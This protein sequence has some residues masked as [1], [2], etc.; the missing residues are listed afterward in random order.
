MRGHR[1]YPPA[2]TGQTAGGRST[3][4]RST[5]RRTRSAVSLRPG[6]AAGPAAPAAPAATPLL[7][8]AVVAVER[9]GVVDDLGFGGEWLVRLGGH[10]VV[11]VVVEVGHV[12]VRRRGDLLDPVGG[13]LLGPAPATA[14][15]PLGHRLGV[16]HHATALAV[17]TGLAERL[18]EAGAD[19]LA[20]P[21]HKPQRGP[22][23]DLV[24]GPVPAEALGQPAQHQVTVA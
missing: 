16:D 18:Q 13:A 22:L 4:I 17:L 6:P 2:R 23:G 15:T 8:V 19:P 7:I 24:L 21:L 1:P 14:G 9:L 20:G 10:D 3:S 11:I 12:P 5:A